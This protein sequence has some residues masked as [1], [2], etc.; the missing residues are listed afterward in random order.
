MYNH[1]WIKQGNIGVTTTQQMIDAEREIV[2]YDIY[3]VIADD[4]HAKFCLDVY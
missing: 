3:R 2:V 1:G 4:Y